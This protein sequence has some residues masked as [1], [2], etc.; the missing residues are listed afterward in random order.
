MGNVDEE[1]IGKMVKQAYSPVGI[2][3]NLKRQVRQGLVEEIGHSSGG[4]RDILN[5]PILIISIT[6]SISI[7]LVVYGYFASMALA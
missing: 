4:F 6:A 1:S 3:S 2:P 7:G 5:R